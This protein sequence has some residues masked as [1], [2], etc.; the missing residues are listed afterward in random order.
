MNT[1]FVSRLRAVALA[2]LTLMTV[3]MSTP[4]AGAQP[5]TPYNNTTGITL[6]QG[7]RLYLNDG[8]MS[9]TLGYIDVHARI[10]YTAQHCGY[11]N[12]PIG[13]P[14]TVYRG[15]TFHSIGTL[16]YPHSYLPHVP[17]TQDKQAFKKQAG[18]ATANEYPDIAAIKLNGSVTHAHNPYSTS[19]K[20]VP[21]SHLKIGDK[22]CYYGYHTGQVKCG[23]IDL[24]YTKAH[25]FY[26]VLPDGS[27][28]ISG[29]SGGPVF[30]PDRT[31]LYGIISGFRYSTPTSL[32]ATRV[33]GL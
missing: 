32:S 31:K 7:D 28:V 19:G 30:S 16:T 27:H 2:V 25:Q 10:A 23:Y 4:V 1:P 21:L 17:F 33:T 6:N 12:Y 18:Q 5:N 9:C 8:K 3:G 26:L 14:V 13:K 24:K 20:F 11:P 29:D 15:G 22:A